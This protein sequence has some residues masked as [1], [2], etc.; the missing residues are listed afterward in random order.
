MLNVLR[1]GNGFSKVIVFVTLLIILTMGIGIFLFTFNIDEAKS[2][3]RTAVTTSQVNDGFKD[4][5]KSVDN[6]TLVENIS[7]YSKDGIE[8]FKYPTNWGKPTIFKKNRYRG[9]EE[10]V[11]EAILVFDSLGEYNSVEIYPANDLHIATHQ[12]T[13]IY[14]KDT[15]TWSFDKNQ[16]YVMVYRKNDDADYIAIQQETQCQPVSQRDY[17]GYTIY[18]FDSRW[19]IK[20]REWIDMDNGYIYAIDLSLGGLDYIPNEHAAIPPSKV[21]GAQDRIEES[22]AGFVKTFIDVNKV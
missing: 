19:T 12:E 21:N 5:A 13:C 10:T 7:I 18:N 17:L 14:D 11:A 20:Q 8:L 15:K 1:K 3:P 9:E 2:K 6:I 22:F 4:R 16:D